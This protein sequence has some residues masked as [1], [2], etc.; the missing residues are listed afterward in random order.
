M[1]CKKEGTEFIQNAKSQP[2]NPKSGEMADGGPT[3]CSMLVV[4]LRQMKTV[5]TYYYG[6]IIYRYTEV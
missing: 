1:K 3:P 6:P 5:S 4:T 2:K